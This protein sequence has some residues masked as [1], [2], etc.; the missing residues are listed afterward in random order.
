MVLQREARQQRST[1][2]CGNSPVEWV[3]HMIR[4]QNGF[5]HE[6]VEQLLQLC[7]SFIRR[8]RLKHKG[9]ACL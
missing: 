7:W 5:T 1:A 9:R 3:K 6:A 4:G 8:G 2:V